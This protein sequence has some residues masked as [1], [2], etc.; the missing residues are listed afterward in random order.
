MM[1]SFILSV[2]FMKALY[3]H[4]K[5]VDL[6]AVR[7]VLFESSSQ[8]TFKQHVTYMKVAL[9]LLNYSI[10]SLTRNF[11]SSPNTMEM[12]TYEGETPSSEGAD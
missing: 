8:F 11:Y 12:L 2:C 4:G 5:S 1:G 9:K 6:R 10:P 3:S 7:V